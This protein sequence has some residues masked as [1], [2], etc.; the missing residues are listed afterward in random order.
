MNKVEFVFLTI[1][2]KSEIL[3][4]VRSL[5][6]KDRAKLYDVVNSISKYGI[7]IAAKQKWIKKLDPDI[8]EIRSKLGTNI[9][10]C[11]YFHKQGNKYVITHG[12]T[13][14]TD[15]TPMREIRHARSLM[16]RSRLEDE[17]R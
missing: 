10:R 5:P 15:K 4:F 17:K 8:Y 6:K 14:K 9:Q 7:L 12:F 16:N 3:D 13:K 11:F 1:K 2:G